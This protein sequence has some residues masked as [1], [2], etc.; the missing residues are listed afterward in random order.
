[1]A[2][3]CAASK[4]DSISLLR[5]PFL[6]YLYVFL[7]AILS[8]CHGW[9]KNFAMFG[10]VRRFGTLGCFCWGREGEEPLWTLGC[11]AHLIFSISVT[12]QI[13]LA[14]CLQK[15]FEIRK[16]SPTWAY[17]IIEVLITRAKFLQPSGYCTMINCTF[18]FCMT[19]V[20]FLLLR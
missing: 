2:L 5:F 8:F 16:I 20:F 9:V 4:R 3:F 17:L 15:C 12:R 13:Y 10:N 14:K 6:S 7:N 1:M 11:W 19:N 18:T